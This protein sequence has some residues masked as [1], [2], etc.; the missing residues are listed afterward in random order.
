MDVVK[1]VKHKVVK[2]TGNEAFQEE[3]N[4]NHTK[5]THL[6]TT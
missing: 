3:I 1:Y 2:A 6:S 5:C 4:F